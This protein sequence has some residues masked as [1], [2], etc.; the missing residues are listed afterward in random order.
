MS[1]IEYKKV[2]IVGFYFNKNFFFVDYY[3]MSA[4]KH[5]CLQKLCS[6]SKNNG[7]CKRNIEYLLNSC[8]THYAFIITLLSHSR[9]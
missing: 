4:M 1:L 9:V 6:I 2:E 3:G 8:I 5:F 7:L